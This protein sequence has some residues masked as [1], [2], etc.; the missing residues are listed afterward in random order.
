L[1]AKIAAGIKKPDGLFVVM[2]QDAEKFLEPLAIREIPGI[3]PKTAQ[4]LYGL[5]IKFVKD[6]RALSKEQLKE[7]LGKWGED[8]YFKIRGIDD[9]PIV[10]NR[11]AKSIG[12]Q[13]TF[14]Q[15]TLSALYIGEELSKMCENVFATF[16]QSGFDKFKT[17]AITV[18]FSNFTTKTSSKSPKKEF[19]RSDLHNFKLEALKLMLPY[20]DKRKNLNLQPIR[21]IGVRAEKLS[22][23]SQKS[24]WQD[25]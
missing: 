13:A 25:Y 2:P 19:G 12:E 14:W 24:L 10:E 22:K 6:L 16:L 23:E 11:E 20:L 3:G 1:V 21:L 4:I 9:S 8:L 7:M 5:N 15:D 17:V 18:R